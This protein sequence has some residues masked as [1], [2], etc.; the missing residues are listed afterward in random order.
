VIA[1]AGLGATRL[2]TVTSHC[3]FDNKRRQA[4]CIR[5]QSASGLSARRKGRAR[6]AGAQS[7]PGAAA[8][9]E[10]RVMSHESLTPRAEVSV[11]QG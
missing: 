9:P 10:S 5:L 7:S 11:A 6:N 4:R 8:S 2:V 3:P 1:N